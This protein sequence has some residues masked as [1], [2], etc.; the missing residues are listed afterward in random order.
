MKH[1]KIKNT[2]IIFEILCNKIVSETLNPKQPQYATKILKRY[3]KNGTLLNT[4]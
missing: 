2:G 4:E 1:N 3:F